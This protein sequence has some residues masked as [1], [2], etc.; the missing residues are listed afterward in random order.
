MT[1][2]IAR[3]PADGRA[4]RLVNHRTFGKTIEQARYECGAFGFNILLVCNAGQSIA[5][6]T[7]GYGLEWHRLVEQRVR[8]DPKQ[9]GC[10]ARVKADSN[11]GG[12]WGEL[13]DEGFGPRSH[14]YWGVV[15]DENNVN[16][17]IRQHQVGV[18]TS[19]G[20]NRL[21]P[22]AQYIL[23]Q[24]R[25]RGELPVVSDRMFNIQISLASVSNRLICTHRSRRKCFP[26]WT[27]DRTFR[28]SCESIGG[29]YCSESI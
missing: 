18:A 9:A 24:Q 15:I 2:R 6:W 25:R 12:T 27:W 21:S 29:G 8:R 16:A 19:R 3:Q 7:T 13:R 28:F 17:S 11:Y 1:I 26:S 14:N 23:H 10:P 5:Q 4:H 20:F 22:E